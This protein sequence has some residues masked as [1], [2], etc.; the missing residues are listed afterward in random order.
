MNS[1]VEHV[2]S[3]GITLWNLGKEG[4]E[5]KMIEHE[6]YYKTRRQRI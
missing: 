4:K 5:E 1:H 3:S 6:Q 2:Y